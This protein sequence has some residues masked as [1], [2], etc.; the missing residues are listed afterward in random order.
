LKYRYRIEIL[1]FGIV[2]ITGINLSIFLL[3]YHGFKLTVKLASV[4]SCPFKKKKKNYAKKRF[5]FV[6]LGAL[7]R[8]TADDISIDVSTLI[9]FNSYVSLTVFPGSQHSVV[10]N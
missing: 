4:I 8:I 3:V 2:P 10:D 7:T 1:F 6:V 9:R 5:T